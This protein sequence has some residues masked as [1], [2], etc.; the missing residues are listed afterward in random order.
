MYK[1]LLYRCLIYIFL[2]T[3]LFD[4]TIDRIIQTSHLS[5]LMIIF[6]L[7]VNDITI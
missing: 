7:K 6:L 3:D 2:R 1:S 5:L 4:F